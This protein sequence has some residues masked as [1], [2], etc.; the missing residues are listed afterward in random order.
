M[1]VSDVE[2][3]D[4]LEGERWAHHFQT[5]PFLIDFLDLAQAHICQAIREAMSGKRFRL[6][7]LM[8]IRRNKPVRKPK[9]GE[10]SYFAEIDSS[11]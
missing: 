11:H 7:K 6:D 8:L 3:M 10:K 1:S 5:H 2:A 4:G 9:K